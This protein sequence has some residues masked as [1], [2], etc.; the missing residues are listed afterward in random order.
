MRGA[1]T[2]DEGWTT[3]LR[4]HE[5]VGVKG[6]SRFLLI[7]L[8][9][10]LFAGS[11]PAYVLHP[12]AD[13]WNGGAGTPATITYSFMST[14]LAFDESP[15][16]GPGTI[17]AMADFV[18]ADWKAEI[19]AGLQSWSAVAGVTFTEVADSGLPFNAV[20]A[21]NGDIRIGGH[22]FDGAFNVLAHGY[23]PP[24]NGW[25]AAGDVHFDIA[26][27][28]KTPLNPGGPSVSALLPPTSSG[29]R[30]VLCT[31]PYRTR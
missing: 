10:G 13:G 11:A 21:T 6:G 19:E 28:W 24:P 26:E 9:V 5:G 22:P 29:T 4:G 23:Y 14:G 8:L 30:L 2:N 27:S 1:L 25:T 20:G 15:S 7:V 31:R 17:S 16:Y 3:S 12:N 18:A